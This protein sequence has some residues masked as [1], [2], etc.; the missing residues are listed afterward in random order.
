MS[1]C[2]VPMSA[3]VRFANKEKPEHRLLG[4]FTEFEFRQVITL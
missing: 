1:L 4:F 2:I 3:R